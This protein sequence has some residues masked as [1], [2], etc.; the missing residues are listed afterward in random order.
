MKTILIGLTALAMATAVDATTVVYTFGSPGGN[1]GATHTYTVGGLSLVAT[2][3]DNLGHTT[4]LYGKNAGG[5]EIGLG[6]ANDPTGNFEIHY[7]K[8]FVQLDVSLLAGKANLHTFT[9]STNSTTNGEQWGVFASNTA[10]SYSGGPLLTGSTESTQTLNDVL[11]HRYYDFVEINHTAGQGDNF[12]ITSFGVSTV[13]EPAG[14]AMMLIGL[15]AIGAAA[16][17]RPRPARVRGRDKRS[18]PDS[19]ARRTEV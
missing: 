14:W 13:P 1:L 18:L 19:R 6:M 12:L 7:K 5:D 2:G 15:F 4:A 3:Y 8:G 16:R 17:A 9:F 10:G 11:G